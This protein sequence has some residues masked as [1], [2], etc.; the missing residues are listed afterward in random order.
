MKSKQKVRF[1]T[2][3]PKDLLIELINDSIP[4]DQIKVEKDYL[5]TIIGD[6]FLSI[7]KNKTIKK[8]EII[9]YYGF[10]KIIHIIKNYKTWMIFFLILL[11]LL[12][13]VSNVILKI[14]VQTTNPS[15]KRIVLKDLQ[16]LGIKKYHLKVSFQ[17]RQTIKQKLLEKEKNKIEW[18]EIKEV[19]TKYVIFVEPKKLIEESNTCKARHIV[20]KKD[21]VITKI[22]SSSGEIIKKKEDYVQKGEIIISGLIYNKDRIVATRC[23]EGKVYGEVW[24]KVKVSI[25]KTKKVT[26]KTGKETWSFILK[27]PIQEINSHKK[28]R[29]YEKNEYNLINS[30]IVPFQLGIINYKELQVE[31][32]EYTKKELENIAFNIAIKKLSSSNNSVVLSKK[33]LKK[34]TNNSKI[35]IEVFLSM[36]EDIT[37]YQEI[38]EKSLEE[39]NQ[40]KE[41]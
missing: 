39:W 29:N 18:I 25:P 28:Y 22:E 24:Y 37:D 19:G 1:Y 2:R 20:S 26:K 27:T 32:K 30:K 6:E 3:H 12:I 4:L 38:E 36:E 33:V 8:V 7:K 40:G 17:E 11:S 5:E 21:A 41:G 10:R 15:L 35:I 23:T 34:Y 14:E 31:E 9:E 16:E 13:L